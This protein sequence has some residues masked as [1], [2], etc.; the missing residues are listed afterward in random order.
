MYRSLCPLA[1]PAAPHQEGIIPENK[2]TM[3]SHS[4]LLQKTLLQWSLLAHRKCPDC[5]KWP[6]GPMG[7]FLIYFLFL[8]V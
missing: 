7:F 4:P 1:P 8:I 6:Q 3:L 2:N 5:L